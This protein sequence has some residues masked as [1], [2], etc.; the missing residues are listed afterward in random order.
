MCT[1]YGVLSLLLCQAM[2]Y[3]SVEDVAGR[4]AIAKWTIGFCQALRAHLQQDSDLR[5]ELV[6]ASP[7]WSQ[8][9]IEMLTTSHH[10]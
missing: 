1:H 4:E 7:A 6:K 3:T 5:A 9:E 10:R 2:S 8:S